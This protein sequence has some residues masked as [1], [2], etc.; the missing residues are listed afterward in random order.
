MSAGD[1]LQADRHDAIVPPPPDPKA[2]CLFAF[3]DSTGAAEPPEAEEQ[4]HSPLIVHQVGS[5]AALVG[6]VP[7]A[8]YCGAD[9]ERNLTDI[10]WLAPR[11]RYH[12]E[13]VQRAM[14][15][16]PV[17]P[18]P[19]GTLYTSFPN[20][21]AFML[22]HEDT[23]V[24]FLRD[25]AGKEEWGLKATACLTAHETLDAL[26]RTAWPDWHHLT[27]GTRYL[28]LC[29]ER[30]ALISFGRTRARQ[31]VVDLVG[32][33]RPLAAD[34]RELAWTSAP[35]DAE[36]EPIGSF[37]LLLAA[38][39]AGALARHVRELSARATEL[40]ITLALSGPWPPFSFR[41]NLER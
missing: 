31:L 36:A 40:Q 2:I 35:G 38:S 5:I 3:I 18:A 6:M 39:E 26:A 32:E 1:P 10:G 27:P 20:L 11:G 25:V 37:A 23:I 19:F 13:V 9:G 15:R 14:R 33:L 12:A 22:R 28:R 24:R 21:T 30:P 4:Q 34:M 8:D 29:R 16:S 7:L 41:P 17:F